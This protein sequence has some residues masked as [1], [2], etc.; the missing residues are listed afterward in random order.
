[1]IFAYLPPAAAR[2]PS[3]MGVMVPNKPCASSSGPA[4]KKSVVVGPALAPLPKPLPPRKQPRF[5]H[6]SRWFRRPG[7]GWSPR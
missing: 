7:E 2:A 1:M 6:P 4:E 5:M 3:G